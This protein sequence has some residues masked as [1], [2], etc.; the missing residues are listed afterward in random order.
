MSQK[1]ELNFVESNPFDL[2]KFHVISMILLC[3]GLV[4]TAYTAYQYQSSNQAYEQASAALKEIKP[5]KKQPIVQKETKPVPVEELKQ[6]REAVNLLSTPWNALF[7]AVEQIDMKDVALLSIDPS[8]KKQRV[9]F[10]G[11]AKNM[12]AALLYIEAL[13][14]LPMLS[15]VYLQ[16]HNIDQQDP[17]KPVGFTILA[18]WS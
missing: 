7:S 10:N 4:I 5:E 12:Q 1:L 16:K 6:V 9:V 11:Q 14:A 15:Q 3:L 18:Q 2:H 8:I 17:Y 13:E